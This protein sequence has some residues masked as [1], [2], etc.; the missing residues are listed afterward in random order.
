[1]ILVSPDAVCV[2]LKKTE[3]MMVLNTCAVLKIQLQGIA[4]HYFFESLSDLFPSQH[5]WHA[6][7][8]I[9]I[10]ESPFSQVATDKKVFLMPQENNKM[11]S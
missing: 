6:E 3:E 11:I 7:L 5:F 10:S 4:Y 9:R 2:S 1:M 8:Q